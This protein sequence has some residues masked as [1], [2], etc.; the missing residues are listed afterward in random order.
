VIPDWRLEKTCSIGFPITSV[1]IIN[2]T[3]MMEE[4]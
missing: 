3:M 4:G 2:K 1:R